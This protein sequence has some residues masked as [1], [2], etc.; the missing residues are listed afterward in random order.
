MEYYIE[1]SGKRRPG[2]KLI[3]A[4]GKEYLTRSDRPAFKCEKGCKGQHLEITCSWCNNKF[5][6]TYSKTVKSKSGK[7]FCTRVC[8]DNAQS[9][10]GIKEIMPPHYGTSNGREKCKKLLK[11]SSKCIGCGETKKYLLCVHHKNGNQDVNEDWNL[12]VVCGNCHIK[13]HLKEVDGCW[14]YCTKS[15]T[16]RDLLEML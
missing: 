5:Y 11:E 8:K 4:C 12:E 3:C 6:R 1:K 2:I 14:L 15:L 10:G 7:L 13:R 9:I 16:P